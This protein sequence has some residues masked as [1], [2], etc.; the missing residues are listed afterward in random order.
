[1]YLAFAAD[2]IGFS[3]S[4]RECAK[5]VSKTGYKGFWF[6]I[7]RDAELS[8][9][10]TRELLEEFK[11][12]PAGFGLPVNFRTDEA[13]FTADLAKLPRYAE[14]A[15]NVGLSRCMT[16]IMPGSDTLEYRE[17]FDLHRKRLS[18]VA[19]ILGANGISLGLE[20]V[21]PYT[22]R[23][24][25]KYEFIH[26]LDGALELSSAIKTGHTGIV[27]D[28]F[29]WDT[30]RQKRE[31]FAR[32]GTEKNIILVHLNDAPSGVPL[33]EQLDN[34]RGLPGAYGT[35]RFAEFFDG[36]KSLGYT[37]PAVVEP[38]YP[39]LARMSFEE[40]AKAVYASAMKVWKDF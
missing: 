32:L 20:F 28:I 3:L 25:M 2:V 24:D 14:F 18:E 36:L 11:L 39:A 22:K 7:D 13:V 12:L 1:M 35:L 21:G 9:S 33:D 16:W 6:N 4:F 40:A 27:M 38:F 23:K 29:H 17:N 19:A 37:G 30:A 8:V 26:N 34:V 15:K 31:D 5:I 10:E